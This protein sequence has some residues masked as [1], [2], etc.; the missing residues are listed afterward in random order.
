MGEPRAIE[1]SAEGK[2]RVRQSRVSLPLTS[3]A[4]DL[5][6]R[7]QLLLADCVDVVVGMTTSCRTRWR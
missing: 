3:I 2:E 6:R 1:A 4:A 7:A 5:L